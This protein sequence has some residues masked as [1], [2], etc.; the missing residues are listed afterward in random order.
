[1][2]KKAA[3]K[4]AA[5]RK[6]A[7]AKVTNRGRTTVAKKAV[8]AGV[9]HVSFGVHGMT[10]ILNE[11]GKAGLEAEFNKAV[12]PDHQFV[13]VKRES[14]EK[15]KDFIGGRPE[16]RNLATAMRN[17]DCPEDDPYCFYI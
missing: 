7:K 6:S 9:S 12:G 17:C 4:A 3:K 1:M 8:R 14:L 10:R 13:T 15:I 16:L 5:A 11:I 2:A